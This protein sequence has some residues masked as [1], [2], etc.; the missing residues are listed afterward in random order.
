LRSGLVVCKF[1]FLGRAHVLVIAGN[2]VA[3]VS[4]TS[5]WEDLIMRAQR[6]VLGSVAGVFAVAALAYCCGGYGSAKT[7]VKLSR[8]V[9]STL[10]RDGKLYAVNDQGELLMLARPNAEL[11]SLGKFEGNLL[12]IADGKGCFAV[13]NM[14]YVA[15]LAKGTILA[16]QTFEKPNPQVCF[17]GSDRLAVLKGGSVQILDAAT[18]KAIHT[19]ELKENDKAPAV[20]AIACRAHGDRLYVAME[21]RKSGLIVIDVQKNQIIDNIPF[22]MSYGLRQFHI[23]E[24]KALLVSHN[25]G[26]YGVW[27]YYAS[28]VDLKTRKATTVMLPG[29]LESDAFTFRGRGPEPTV[30][31]GPGEQFCLVGPTGVFRYDMQGKLIGQALPKTEG[32]VLTLWNRSAVIAGKD[33][34]EIVPLSFKTARSE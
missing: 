28:C 12:D 13:K 1:I 10:V 29:Q 6:I 3:C 2:A 16:S 32:R 19:I 26:A 21:G 33:A 34:L 31:V 27:L 20:N 24:G 30:A 4:P 25:H 22:Q 5:S 17:V 11:K 18:A 8:P 15:D 7:T 14:V 9:Q 23:H